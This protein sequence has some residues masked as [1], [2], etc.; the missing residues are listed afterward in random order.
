MQLWELHRDLS[1][2]IGDPVNADAFVIPDGVRY[3]RSKRNDYLYR[4]M[5]TILNRVIE[6][7]VRLNKQARNKIL[8]TILPNYISEIGITVSTLPVTTPSGRTLYTWQSGLFPYPLY[9]Y[10]LSVRYVGALQSYPLPIKVG[11]EV[12]A[13]M[14]DRY[15]QP[16][17]A[18]CEYLGGATQSLLIYDF[19]SEL[20]GG[21]ILVEYIPLPTH[22]S[23]LT[24]PDNVI[25]EPTLLPQVLSWATFLALSDSQ[26]LDNIDKY[27][28]LAMSGTL[29]ANTQP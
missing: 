25:F 11:T 7:T 28:P 9:V 26:D 13:L 20:S 1:E 10:I 6:A 5:L 16:H 19:L 23:F 4:S 12:E 17:D 24:P 8:K 14:N 15:I 27:L 21:S 18:F 2:S 29:N 3:N 22:P